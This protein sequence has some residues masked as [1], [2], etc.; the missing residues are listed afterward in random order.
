MQKNL[1]SLQDANVQVVAV[2][3]DSVKVLREFGQRVR[4]GFPLLSDPESKTIEAYGIRN[5]EMK[6]KRIDG[7]PYPGTFLLD[8]SG[9]IRE[10]LFFEDYAERHQAK[11][12]LKATAKL[13][14]PKK[15]A[16]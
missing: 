1:K 2:S 13:P 11:D 15:Q 12:I 10:K 14:K 9:V 6:G 8:S 3:Y 7:V 4:I 16:T 5:K